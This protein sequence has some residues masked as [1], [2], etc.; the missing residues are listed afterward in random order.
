MTASPAENAGVGS[1]T[2]RPAFA[3][4]LLALSE[5]KVLGTGPNA[6]RL[7]RRSDSG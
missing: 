1:S 7:R 5:N 6:S 2:V 4:L 3:R